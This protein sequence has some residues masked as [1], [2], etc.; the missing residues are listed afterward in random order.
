LESQKNFSGIYNGEERCS[1]R[2]ILKT[3]DFFSRLRTERQGL[4]LIGY[5]QEYLREQDRSLVP[6]GG[7]EV[8]LLE[9][10]ALL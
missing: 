10:I 3:S 5:G 4:D 1:I 7:P 9:V 6:Y 8:R 2:W